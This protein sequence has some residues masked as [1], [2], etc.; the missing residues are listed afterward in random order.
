MS[1]YDNIHI[2][3]EFNVC[4]T[5]FYSSHSCRVSSKIFNFTPICIQSNLLNG[6]PIEV[7][8]YDFHYNQPLHNG[9]SIE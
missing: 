3:Y 6:P 9:H 5:K 2:T 8:P 1:T 4:I 7:P